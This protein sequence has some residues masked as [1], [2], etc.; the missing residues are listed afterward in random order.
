MSTST[1]KA[2][3]ALNRARW[4]KLPKWE[5]SKKMSELAQIRWRKKKQL[6]I[7]AEPAENT[8]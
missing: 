3:S 2:A 1:S 7:S 4:A 6:K 8:P 5:R